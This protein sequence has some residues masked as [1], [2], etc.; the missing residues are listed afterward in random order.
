MPLSPNLRARAVGSSATYKPPVSAGFQN[1]PMRCMVIAQGQT[2]VSFSATKFQAFSAQEVGSVAGYNS[3]AYFAARELWPSGRDGIGSIP[4]EFALLGD[5][6]GS[7]ASTGAIDVSGTATGKG[8]YRVLLNRIACEQFTVPAGAVDVT[9][10]L[11]KVKDSVDAKLGRPI[12]VAYTYGSPS[13]TWVRAGGTPSNGTLGSF[14]TTGNPKP[15]AWTLECTA[16]AGNAGT[17]KLTDPDGTVVSTT[18]TVGAQTQG[19][20][21]FTLSDGSEDFNI[22]DI[23]TITVPVTDLVTTSTW[24]GLTAND[25][26]IEIEGPSL[27]VEWAITQHT[28]GS[29]DPSVA[30]ALSQLG[31]EKWTTLILNGLSWENATALNAFKDA[32]EDRWDPT[33]NKP[34]VA[35]V[36]ANVSTVAEAIEIPDARKDDRVNVQIPSMGSKNLPIAIAARALCR[37]AVLSDSIPSHDYCLKKLDGIDPGVDSAAWKLSQRDAAMKGG[38]STLEIVDSVPRLSNVVTF[39]HPTGEEPPAWSNLV[40]LIKVWNVLYNI[41]RIFRTEEWAGA[42]LLPDAQYTTE[43]TAKKPKMAVADVCSAL[44]ALGAKAIISDPAASKE[45]VTATIGGGGANPNRL[46]VSGHFFVSG[47]TH[48]IDVPLTWSF[49]FPAA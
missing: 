3:P 26:Q 24:K 10:T 30:N 18:V 14:T 28:G 13:A 2:G 8:T 38:S 6:S 27:G 25:I 4:V 17:F 9:A 35:L 5:A 29:V 19:G 46:D 20:L 42:A 43:A 33:V 15:G 32:S 44:D 37:I 11:R 36:G 21:G 39:W 48:V 22:G 7:A 1:L 34:F 45:T 41:D 49:Y 47:N 23:A 12:N 31:S 16:E 40:T